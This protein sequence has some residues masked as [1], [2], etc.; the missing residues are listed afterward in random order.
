[1]RVIVQGTLHR[2]IK[3]PDYQDKVGKYALQLMIDTQLSNGY[4]KTDIHTISI[5]DNKVPDY[6]NKE[7]EYVSVECGIIGKAPVFYG[8]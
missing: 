7:G 8:V 6:E 4:T 2:L 3:K 1:M 5:P